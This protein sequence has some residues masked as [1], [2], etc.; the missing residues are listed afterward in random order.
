M[1]KILCVSENKND[2]TRL[3]AILNKNSYDFFTLSDE[4]QILDAIQVEMPDIIILDSEFL[5]IKTLAKKLK[6]YL[7][8]I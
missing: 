1:I 6:V 7:I 3:T 8:T 4:T 5:N 2:I